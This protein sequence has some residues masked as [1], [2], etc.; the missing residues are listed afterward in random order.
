MEQNQKTKMLLF[1]LFNLLC[2]S[3]IIIEII[4]YVCGMEQVSK[5]LMLT[6]GISIGT[7]E[8]FFKREFQETFVVEWQK[9]FVEK[10]SSKWNDKKYSTY[11]G[12]AI[13]LFSFV[14]FFSSY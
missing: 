3:I 1:N 7:T 10:K 9:K 4:L 13:I 14:V 11:V 2:L 6:L 5:Y 8:I 12:A